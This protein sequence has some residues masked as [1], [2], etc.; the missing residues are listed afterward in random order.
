MSRM[1]SQDLILAIRF[2]FNKKSFILVDKTA[3]QI[4]VLAIM[5][6]NS[7]SALW[8]HMVEGQNR[9]PQIVLCSMVSAHIHTRL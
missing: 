6:D 7:S 9:L 8:T 3:L 2:M 5:A 4:K 1:N